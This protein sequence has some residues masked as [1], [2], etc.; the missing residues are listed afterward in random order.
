MPGSA[1]T[2]EQSP[3]ALEHEGAI[4]DESACQEATE[5]AKPSKRGVFDSP[6][7]RIDPE[8]SCISVVNE[9]LT[10]AVFYT[11]RLS[12]RRGG[13]AYGRDLVRGV[14]AF[15]GR[16]GGYKRDHSGRR[17]AELLHLQQQGLF[18]RRAGLHRQQSRTDV[19]GRGRKRASQMEPDQRFGDRRSLSGPQARGDQI[20]A[21]PGPVPPGGFVRP[22]PRPRPLW[23][24][25]VLPKP[26]STSLASLR[27]P[28]TRTCARWLRF[29]KSRTCPR[30]LRS[31]TYPPVALFR[32]K[33]DARAFGPVVS[34]DVKQPYS[35][36]GAFA[37]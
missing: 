33:P 21:A 17:S 20:R 37:P 11:F 15:N 36:R 22:K 35:C 31:A 16:G 9:K 18:R 2:R 26:G 6:N 28:K 8:S 19:R 3:H 32:Q 12:Q 13:N 14:P 10:G 5:Q 1:E 23:L 30:W 24:R 27:S 34:N 29:H 4:G 25:F 7:P